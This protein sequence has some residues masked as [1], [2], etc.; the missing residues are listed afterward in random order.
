MLLFHIIR[1]YHDVGQQNVKYIC[2]LITQALVG[3]K[4]KNQ[5]KNTEFQ[6]ITTIH[7]TD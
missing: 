1:K 4:K 7:R 3:K 6:S 5:R 2:E